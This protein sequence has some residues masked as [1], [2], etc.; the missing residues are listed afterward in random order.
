[1]KVWWESEPV[2]DGAVLQA[3]LNGGQS[4]ITVGAF[5][6]PDWYTSNTIGS[7]PG[8]Q[9]SGWT[10]LAQSGNGSNGWI[11][12]THRLPQTLIGQPSVRF[13]VLFASN[14]VQQYDGFAFDDVAIGSPPAL[15]LGADG[16]YCQGH[17][18]S[19]G[20]ASA[21]YQWSTGASSSSV[22]LANQTGAPIL[23]SII[24]VRATASNGLF[25]RDT[26]RFSMPVPLS[27][28]IDSIRYIACYGAA[29]GGIF[30]SVQGGGTPL[31]YLWSNQSIAQDLVNVPSGSYSVVVSD[32]HN[33]RLELPAQSVPQSSPLV[34]TVN[35][36]HVRC[37][38]DSTG[39]VIVQPGGGM[40]GYVVSWL[41]GF[42][43][44]ARYG[45]P[46]GVYQIRLTDAGGC[47]KI[48][49][50]TINE[51]A[52]ISA[53]AEASPAAC[54]DS[55]DGQLV[56]TPQGGTPPYQAAWAHGAQGL[57]LT[58]IPAGPYHA[59]LTDANQCE[60]QTDTFT[61]GFSKALPQAW[62]GYEAQGSMVSF[63]DSSSGGLTWRWSFGDG[64]SSTLRN[65]VHTYQQNGDYTVQA[66][67]GNSCGAD[68]ITRQLQMLMVS[69]P[70]DLAAKGLLVWPNPAQ[71]Q[72]R[73]RAG[74]VPPGP[75]TL[76]LSDLSGRVHLRQAFRHPGGML[77]SSLQ[78]GDSMPRGLYQIRLM[79][80]GGTASAGAAVQ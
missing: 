17:V 16:Y 9:S 24:T 26:L 79:H 60:Y 5:G 76:E 55:P 38:G 57:T 64:S 18:L 56:L 29:T 44:A 48:H 78:I 30:I 73:V 47:L 20:P 50:L 72:I 67:V 65:P 61:V 41:D 71:D 53:A 46:Q 3:T 28:S 25:R 80:A 63:R 40:G 37:H 51:P 45:M 10:G 36:T 11:A 54:P 35:T 14:G 7:Q 70:D 31:G 69:I 32:V 62:F 12:V 39:S 68:T 34:L 74:D 43:G 33:C 15:S 49:N 6:A 52:P 59:V 23:D 58:G 8:G 77:E 21:A 22:T 66:I 1:M 19:P 4:W 2:W 75:V 27:A 42:Q 13:R